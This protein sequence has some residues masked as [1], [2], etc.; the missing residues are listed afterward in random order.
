MTRQG[1]ADRLEWALGAASAAVVLV[2]VGY[3]VYEGANNGVGALATNSWTT[4]M[5]GS[6]SNF[7]FSPGADYLGTGIGRPLATLQAGFTSPAGNTFS[8]NTLVLGLSTGVGSGRGTA[9]LR[10]GCE[11]RT[12]G[13]GVAAGAS[14][15]GCWTGTGST[16]Q[17]DPAISR[18][19]RIRAARADPA[20]RCSWSSRTTSASRAGPSS[21][22]SS[23]SDNRT[24]RTLAVSSAARWR[25][26]G[27]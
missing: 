15:A 11:A 18:D 1:T 4:M 8:A 20:A 13:S 22:S 26:L 9:R 27:S 14:V 16:S 23:A 25:P 24:P 7:W 6:T 21:R 10:S 12:A 2:L 17:N 5:I 3:L 19:S